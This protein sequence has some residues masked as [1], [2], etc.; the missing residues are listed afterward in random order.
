MKEYQSNSHKSKEERAAAETTTEKRVEKVVSGNV[1]TRDNK[2][3]KFADI[4]ISEDAANVKSYVFMDVLVP[5]IKKAISDIVTDGI[6]MVLY[7]STGGSR[8][9]SSGGGNKVS[10]RSYYDDR[11]RDRRDEHVA[12]TRFEYDDIIFESR[13][14]AERVRMQMFD[15]IERYGYVTVAD[16]YDLA[17]LSAPYTGYNYGWTNIRTSEVQRVR[18]GYVLRL[19]IAMPID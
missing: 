12:R 8:R 3:R 4:F 16:M 7:G 11:P 5:A 6:D 10:Y 14:D 13:T 15:T 1:K 2:A 18:D 19:P 9:K 17:D